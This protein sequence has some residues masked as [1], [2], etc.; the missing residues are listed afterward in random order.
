MAGWGG[1][2]FVVE[3]AF[4]LGTTGTTVWVVLLFL[5]GLAATFPLHATT[6]GPTRLFVAFGLCFALFV[7]G[8]AFSVS[9]AEVALSKRI[10]VAVALGLPLAALVVRRWPTDPRDEWFLRHARRAVPLCLLIGLPGF[11]VGAFGSLS[12]DPAP[13]ERA[14]AALGNEPFGAAAV[15]SIAFDRDEQDRRRYAWL[16]F[17]QG[18]VDPA[19]FTEVDRACGRFLASEPSRACACAGV[20]M[21][22]RFRAIERRRD[23]FRIAL[24]GSAVPLGLALL[25]AWRG[26]RVNSTAS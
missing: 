3:T 25:F 10:A 22:S 17:A 19:I 18:A 1:A 20:L 5:V 14:L 12:A 23:G 7:E 15:D 4:A 8:L 24:L 26:R 2:L 21:S 11:A 16:E 13:Y 6:R 9:A